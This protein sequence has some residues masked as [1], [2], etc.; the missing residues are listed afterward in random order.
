MEKQVVQELV[1]ALAAIQGLPDA[2]RTKVLRL[3]SILQ[4]Y[5]PAQF[6]AATDGVVSQPA[7]EQR[8]SADDPGWAVYDL[9]AALDEYVANN[10]TQAIDARVPSILTRLRGIVG[11]FDRDFP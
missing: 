9:Y 4:S 2:I 11:G 8:W 1:S 6:A 10:R 3:E 5:S 7:A